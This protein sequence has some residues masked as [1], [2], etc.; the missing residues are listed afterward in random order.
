ML[1]RDKKKE[2]GTDY[3]PLAKADLRTSRRNFIAAASVLATAGILAIGSKPAKAR[4]DGIPGCGPSGGQPNKC[5]QHHCFL[6]GTHI[7]TPDG[8]IV[9]DE[10]RI[11][12][13]VTTVSGRAKPIKWIG[14]NRYTRTSS[15]NV[16]S[17]FAPGEGGQVRSQRPHT[18]R[19][20]IFI[21]RTR[22]LSAGPANTRCKSR[23]RQEHRLRAAYKLL[24]WTISTS[25]GGAQRS[26]GRGRRRGNL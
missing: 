8:Q 6:S 10:L 9:I 5:V 1:S 16:N 11:G 2:P 25:I 4:Q 7:A 22:A 24:N 13:L 18:K 26:A 3:S 17:G 15:E 19:R 20:S 12:D 21:P 23:K 14:R